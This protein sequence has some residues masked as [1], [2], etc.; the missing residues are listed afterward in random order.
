SRAWSTAGG[1][2]STTGRPRSSAAFA[3]AAVT[4]ASVV[5]GRA[6]GSDGIVRCGERQRLRAM[7]ERRY[8]PAHDT[9]VRPLTQPAPPRDLRDDRHLAG[10]E[11]AQGGRRGRD[12]PGGG[13]ARFPDAGPP[14]RR[15]R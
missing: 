8:P 14:V 3:S 6:N 1:R 13:G 11:A 4:R 2:T 15:R 10:G 9:G 7:T 5:K 12:R